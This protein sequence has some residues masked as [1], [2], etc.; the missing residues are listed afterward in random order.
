MTDTAVD[1]SIVFPCLN[2]EATL[3]RCI[4]AAR[5]ALDSAGLRGEIIV[6]DNGSTD[7][8]SAIALEEGAR[9]VSV[10]ARGYGNALFSGL[11]AARGQYL[12]HLDADMSYECAHIPRFVEQ[13]R[14]G[15]DLVMGSRL[16]GHIDPG[17][18]PFSHRHLGTPVLT[19]LA[20]LFFGSHIS[21]IN[22]GMRGLT[23]TAFERLGLRAG[24]MEF[25][26]EMVVKA[27]ALHM[28]IVEIPTDLHPDERG[29]RPHLSTVRDGW[30][31]LRF[32]LLFCPTW[33]FVWPGVVATVGGTGVILAILFDLFPYFGL[34]TCLAALAVTVLGV[35]TILL[36][37]A[38][39]RFAQLR[40]LRVA[41]A[42]NGLIERLTLEKGL[43]GGGTLAVVGLAILATAC[44]RILRFM[45]L[46]GYD[47]SQLDLASTKLALLGTTLFVTG[48]QVVFSSFFLGLF[49]I[50]PLSEPP[51]DESTP[52]S[53]A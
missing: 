32:L 44:V 47:P 1:I 21:D 29:R 22:C 9:L 15:A 4:G 20:N 6:A 30:R 3:A 2:E 43:V 8:S 24:G 51:A 26:S 52:G 13:L 41:T 37:V 28:N 14:N 34:F 38:A 53:S 12:V 33:L 46:E 31:H 40:R 42:R 48:A 7:R 36:G 35:Q 50:E 25:A 39:G 17:A 11:R 5:E 10:P 23:K 49:N 16:K 19:H 27:A 45:S 18:M